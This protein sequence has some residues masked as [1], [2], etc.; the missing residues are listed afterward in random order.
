[1]GLFWCRAIVIA[2][3]LPAGVPAAAGIVIQRNLDLPQLAS[4]LAE[5]AVRAGSDVKVLQSQ[6]ST[7]LSL[8]DDAQR[9]ERA[10]AARAVADRLLDDGPA[11]GR[12]FL[13]SLLHEM[14]PWTADDETGIEQTF[15]YA[16]RLY[17]EVARRPI[18]D[19]QR[20][21]FDLALASG[22]NFY[23]DVFRVID[24]LSGKPENE[25]EWQA[26]LPAIRNNL[27]R[28]RADFPQSAFATRSAR[29]L[30][31]LGY[32]QRLIDEQPDPDLEAQSRDLCRA[33][34]QTPEI[35]STGE[36]RYRADI[37][38]ECGLSDVFAGRV[39]EALDRFTM[40]Q[41]WP[42]ALAAFSEEMPA[43]DESLLSQVQPDYVDQVYV[44]RFLPWDRRRGNFS[45]PSVLGTHL[46]DLL[47]SPACR[48]PSAETGA[49]AAKPCID[50]VV[51]GLKDFQNR[52]SVIQLASY[53]DEKRAKR[54]RALLDELIGKNAGLFQDA[55]ADLGAGDLSRA[56][57]ALKIVP[58][59]VRGTDWYSLRFAAETFSDR[60]A[61]AILSVF[62]AAPDLGGV[63]PLQIR[64]RVY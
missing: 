42:A 14:R 57:L 39:S 13:A 34:L 43:Y 48:P 59:Q 9:S 17:T 32:W 35:Q 4:E 50:H 46:V 51:A 1:M 3:L 31:Q 22:E 53:R 6:A 56:R 2:L 12:Q 28:F 58:R 15:A 38:F 41:Q 49:A 62:A 8:Y 40:L 18:D 60:E 61:A 47:T 19:E 45:Q 33:V 11:Q 44:V 64:P 63:K 36:W 10:A 5:Q 27:A 54:G 52:D 20:K 25:I 37:E 23:Y 29:V 7:F 55:Y 16:R 21:F 26:K 30:V 24:E